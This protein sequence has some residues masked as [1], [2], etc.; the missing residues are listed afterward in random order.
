MPQLG[1]KMNSRADAWAASLL[2]SYTNS[3][4]EDSEVP[5]SHHVR[6]LSVLLSCDN[7]TYLMA[8]LTN[9][10]KKHL[11]SVYASLCDGWAA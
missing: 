5:V 11:C 6:M 4:R 8:P 9:W 10:L 2:S 1:A 3:P 7:V